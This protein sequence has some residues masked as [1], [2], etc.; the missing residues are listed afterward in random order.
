MFFRSGYGEKTKHS[1]FGKNVRSP[2][3]SFFSKI[4]LIFSEQSGETNERSERNCERRSNACKAVGR[5]KAKAGKAAAETERS[6]RKAEG[7]ERSETT[8]PDRASGASEHLPT[9]SSGQQL[10]RR[11]VQPLCSVFDELGGSMPTIS[12][13]HGK[14]AERNG[15]RTA[16]LLSF[17]HEYG[18]LFAET[19]EVCQFYSRNT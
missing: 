11:E 10:G 17:V 3:R 5:S 13:R 7:G 19:L 9:K 15:G 12:A 18:S 6:E 14:E 4:P 1:I 2:E 16:F 8:E